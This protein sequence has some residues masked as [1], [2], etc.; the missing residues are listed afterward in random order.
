MAVCGKAVSAMT[1]SIA[2]A[3]LIKRPNSM[4]RNIVHRNAVIH[5]RKS[6]A[7]F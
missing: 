4:P 3:M 1:M 5:T 6:L 7:W 2:S